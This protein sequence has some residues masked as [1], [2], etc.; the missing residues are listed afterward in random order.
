MNTLKKK[1]CFF[2]L[3]LKLFVNFVLKMQNAF[4]VAFCEVRKLSLV[5]EYKV[6]PQGINSRDTVSFRRNA[7]YINYY[8]L[9]KLLIF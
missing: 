9:R 7:N 6:L 3:Q 5:I 1:K 2:M 8:R 4:V